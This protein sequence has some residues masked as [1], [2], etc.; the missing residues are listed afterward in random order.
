MVKKL[1]LHSSNSILRF[2]VEKKDNINWC[3]IYLISTAFKDYIIIGSDVKE[4][5]IQK[6][7]KHL[8]LINLMNQKLL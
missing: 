1:S 3:T 8:V 6:L 7:L 2:E 4:I 5:I